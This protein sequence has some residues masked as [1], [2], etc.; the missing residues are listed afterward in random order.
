[1]SRRQTT[2]FALCLLGACDSNDASGGD[3]EATTGG[4][5]STGVATTPGTTN[6]ATTATTEDPTA[7]SSSSTTGATGG[8]TI[9]PEDDTGT[10]EGSSS[11]GTAVEMPNV[12]LSDPQLYEFSFRADE[13]DPEATQVLVPQAAYLDTTVEP[14]G[15]LVVFLHG[16]GTQSN[17]ARPDHGR[18]LAGLGF[19][20]VMP[21]YLSDYGVGN[22]GD[23][24]G[25]CRLEAFEGVDHH[26][27]INVGPSD[28]TETRVVRALEYLQAEHPGGD[29]EFFTDGE[30][31]RYE[32]IVVSGSSHGAST[33][34]LIGMNR[35]VRRVVSLAGPLDSGQA[36]LLGDPMTPIDRFYAFTHTGDNQHEGHL[37]SFEDLGMVGEPTVVDGA[38]PPYG[39][40]HRLVSSAPTGNGHGA[41]TAGSSSPMEN[42]E[43]VFLPVWATMYGADIPR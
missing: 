23:D 17:C 6:P 8:S 11:T 14:I 33:S 26:D 5:T 35:S 24:I 38:E 19:H 37:V 3:T 4:P 27:H 1:M 42:D 18:M 43:W 31:P 15:Q 20:V 16:A 39:D 22:C 40:S 10:T 13:A 2:L 21:C 7:D 32:H 34:A 30:T 12:D 29:W 36:W 28:S 25:G 9:G 41:V